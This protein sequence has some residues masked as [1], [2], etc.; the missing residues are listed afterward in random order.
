M[1]NRIPID[2]VD[3][4]VIGHVTQ[5][6]TPNGPILG[7]TVSYAALTAKAMGLRVGIVTACAPDTDLSALQ[8]IQI[9]PLETEKTTTFENI[10]TP[11]GRIQY[12]HHQ[13]PLL[14]L[15]MVPET[16]RSAPIVHLGPVAREIDPNLARVFPNSFVGLTPQGWMR[17]WDAA[18]RV[19][20]GSWPEAGYVLEKASAAVLSIEDVSGNEAIIE[21]MA[22]RVSILAVTESLNGV[23]V[24]WNGDLRRLRPPQVTEVDPVGAGDIFATVFFIR[25]QVTRDPWEAARCANYLA[26]HSVTRRGLNGIPLKDEIYSCMFEVIKE[27]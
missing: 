6:L 18:G 23:R 27:K 14:D 24:Y 10:Y 2:P 11:Q 26:A 3:Y 22:A 16:W 19:R 1:L 5:D 8:G 7:G 9:A 25:L 15:S 17:E 21:E 12:I 4:L 20:Y 13:A